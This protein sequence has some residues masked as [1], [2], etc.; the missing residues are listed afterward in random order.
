MLVISTGGAGL[1]EL[2]RPEQHQDDGGGNYDQDY[3][4]DTGYAGIV[5]GSGNGG[6]S[7]IDSRYQ[8]NADVNTDNR[9]DESVNGS[10]LRTD[11]RFIFALMAFRFP[12]VFPVE[13]LADVGGPQEH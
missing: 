3:L 12:A 10:Y 13:M 4:D 11:L 6:D 9:Y 8:G 1:A 5:R 7:I 2:R